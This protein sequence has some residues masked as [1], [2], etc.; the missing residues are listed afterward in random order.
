LLVGREI[1]GN[2]KIKN[3]KI[4][5]SEIKNNVKDIKIADCEEFFLNYADRCAVSVH[6]TN[7]II[8]KAAIEIANTY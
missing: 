5:D 8:N 4:K 7:L 2:G 3:D 1:L 6:S